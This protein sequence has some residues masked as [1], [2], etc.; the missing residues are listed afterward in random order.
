MVYQ[1]MSTPMAE[2]R[3]KALFCSAL[4]HRTGVYGW[5][6]AH[7]SKSRTGRRSCSVTLTPL[8][9][10]VTLMSWARWC[11]LYS[12]DWSRWIVADAT[13]PMAELQ[14]DGLSGPVIVFPG[15]V[16]P[17]PV[18]TAGPVLMNPNDPADGSRSIPIGT[19]TPHTFG[20]DGWRYYGDGPG[21]AAL[22]SSPRW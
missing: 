8:T 5:A 22:M 12:G 1:L 6:C 13:T 4:L 7:E 15:A 21:G 16:A 20:Q 10:T 17:E 11:E 14:V 18:Y 9:R 3:V 2:L 19:V